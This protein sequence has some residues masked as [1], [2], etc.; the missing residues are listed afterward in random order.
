MPVPPGT[1]PFPFVVTPATVLRWQ[2][3]RFR[4]HWTQLSGRPTGGRPPV[5]TEITA[6]VRK[7][8]AANPPRRLPAERGEIIGE[9]E[10]A[11]R[12]YVEGAK[13]PRV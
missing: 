1:C 12:H 2:R 7:M 8:A 6:L 10:S 4:E 11:K 3:R 9:L 13:G 5:N